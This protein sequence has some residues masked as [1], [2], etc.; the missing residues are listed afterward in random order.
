MTFFGTYVNETK[1]LILIETLEEPSYAIVMY[2]LQLELITISF[3]WVELR[4]CS[5]F[6]LVVL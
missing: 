6:N 3:A 4:F 5:R 2:L 1:D